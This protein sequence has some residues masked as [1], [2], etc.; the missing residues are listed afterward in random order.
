MANLLENKKIAEATHNISAYRI[1][2]D[3]N[4]LQVRFDY[5]KIILLFLIIFLFVL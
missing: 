4:I 3:K 2:T 1:K 5:K